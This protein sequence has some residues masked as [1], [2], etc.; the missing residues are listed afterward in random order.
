MSR[1]L[2]T[3]VSKNLVT[4]MSSGFWSKNLVTEMSFSAKNL[5]TVVSRNLVIVAP[6]LLSKNLVTEMSFYRNLVTV[7]SRYMLAAAARN[8]GV[9]V[10]SLSS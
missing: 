3:V 8:K 10:C 5:V 4:E 6:L 2:V 7:V 1:N 9:V